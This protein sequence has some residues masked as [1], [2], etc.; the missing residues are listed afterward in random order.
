MLKKPRRLVDQ[1]ISLV[2]REQKLYNEKTAVQK[3]F[4]GVVLVCI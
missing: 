2:G 3:G 1:R 4:K